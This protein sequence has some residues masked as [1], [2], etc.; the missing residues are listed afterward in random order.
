MNKW[1][2]GLAIA[3][4]AVPSVALGATDSDVQ[5]ALKASK[6]GDYGFDELMMGCSYY[7][8]VTL[9]AINEKFKP[10]DGFLFVSPEEFPAY[11]VAERKY[12]GKRFDSDEAVRETAFSPL[13]KRIQRYF[14]DVLEH[15][16]SDIIYQK[17]FIPC[18]NNAKVFLA[19][20]PPRA[21]R[22]TSSNAI[23]KTSSK[24]D[25]H[26][27]CLEARDYEGCIRAKSSGGSSAS[28]S[29]ICM[30]DGQCL[31]TTRENDA[32]GLPKPMGWQYKLM[33]DF[34][35]YWSNWYRVPHK[36]QQS[37]YV[38]LK[39]I[40]RYYR[41]PTAGTSGTVIGGGNSYTNCTGYGSSIN[42]TSSGGGSK[43]IPGQSATPGGIRNMKTNRIYDCKDNTYAKYRGTQLMGK[44]EKNVDKTS[45][46][47]NRLKH[48]C[49]QG[50]AEIMKLD[51]WNFKM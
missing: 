28:D 49:D 6:I 40:S 35:V 44:W 20:S 26:A 51:P 48:M 1:I 47:A 5:R 50:T 18:I 11:R 10:K 31:V 37:R 19:N 13:T 23:P 25:H 22:P 14:M 43:Y 12:L 39:T 46:F 41:N 3:S 27:Q 38:G 16:P 34:V 7:S 8:N 17:V 32:Y 33:D 24:E 9:T 36:G 21:Q 2:S 29:D 30:P 15:Q 45:K 4:L 42:C